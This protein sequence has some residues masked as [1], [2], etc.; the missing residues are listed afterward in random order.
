MNV[1]D[2][3]MVELVEYKLKDVLR[4]CFDQWKDGIGEAEPPSRWACFEE[5]FFGRFFPHKP[6]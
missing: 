2:T 3:K 6:K 4:T 1:V 5:A